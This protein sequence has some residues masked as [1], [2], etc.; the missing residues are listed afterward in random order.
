[1]KVTYGASFKCNTGNF[2]NT[3]RFIQVEEE[4]GQDFAHGVNFEDAVDALAARVEAKLKERLQRIE[5]R[6]TNRFGL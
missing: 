5:D 4:M 6:S 3:D 1:M 2:E